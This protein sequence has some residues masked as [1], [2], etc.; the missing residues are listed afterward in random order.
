[1]SL[2]KNILDIILYFF[3]LLIFFLII[4]FITRLII[5]IP[6]N[7]AIFK[8]G[9]SKTVIFDVVDLSKLQITVVDKKKKL[10]LLKEKLMIKEFG[11]LVGQLLMAQGVRVHIHL[12]GLKN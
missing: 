2:F 1:M 11:F 4:E 6:T 10:I 5:F 8:Y 9:F 7:S 3:Y 12:L